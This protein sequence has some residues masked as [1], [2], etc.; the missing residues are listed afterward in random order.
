MS[1]S[2]NNGEPDSDR[3][4]SAPRARKPKSQADP[5]NAPDDGVPDAGTNNHR[6]NASA[7]SRDPDYAVGYGRPPQQHQF[8]RGQSGNPRGRPKGVRSED[9]ILA[10]LLNKKIPIQ[11]R[12][13]VRHV[14]VLEAVY[15]RVAQNALKGDLKAATFLMNRKAAVAQGRS[16]ETPEMN[17][18]D[19][20]VLDS[21][22]A[23]IINSQTNGGSK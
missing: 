14:S 2:R 13:R 3:D 1:R 9:D 4:P 17:E 22:V 23:Q 8:K 6:T 11:E 18:D 7:A 19:R 12:S 10:K 16:G 21:F 20:A 5:A 15:F